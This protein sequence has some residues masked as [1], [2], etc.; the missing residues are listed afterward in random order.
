M[1]LCVC[2]SERKRD[3][4]Y[5]IPGFGNQL[6]RYWCPDGFRGFL[7]LKASLE[8]PRQLLHVKHTHCRA[9]DAARA[10]EREREIAIISKNMAHIL[11]FTIKYF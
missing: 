2:V 11:H 10:G 4:E 3:R 9:R 8:N 1:C 7:L 6:I 5:R